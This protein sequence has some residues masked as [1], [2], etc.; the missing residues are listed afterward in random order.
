MDLNESLKWDGTLNFKV[1]K[2]SKVVREYKEHNKMTNYARGYIAQMLAGSIQGPLI[3]PS[4]IELGTGSGTAAATDTDLWSPTI[5]TM[6]PCSY[7]QVYLNYFAQYIVT[8]LTTDPIQG[9]W[10]EAGLKDANGN[11][12]AHT[13]FNLTIN[14]GEMLVGQWQVQIVGN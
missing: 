7:T 5:A 1:I 13:A 11:L 8:W 6:K 14:P 12:W 9:T 10:T 2:D 4:Q 3:L